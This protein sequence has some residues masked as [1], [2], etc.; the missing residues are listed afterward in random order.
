MIEIN[1]KCLWMGC[2]EKDTATIFSIHAGIVQLNLITT[3]YHRTHIEKHFIKLMACY[4]LK[5]NP[6]VI[7]DKEKLR[8]NSKLTDERNMT[9]EN[10]IH[11]PVLHPVLEGK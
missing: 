10:V 11:G 4:L 9:Q 8:D 1:F 2:P 5:K 3:K 7:K 6:N